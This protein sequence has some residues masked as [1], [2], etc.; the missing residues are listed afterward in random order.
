MRMRQ[1]KLFA[2]QC[3]E[4]IAKF[5]QDIL[6]KVSQKTWEFRDEFDIF[7]IR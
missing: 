7:K 5:W 2:V 3:T 4:R 1:N 6:Y